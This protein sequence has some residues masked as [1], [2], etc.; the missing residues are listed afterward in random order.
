MIELYYTLFPQSNCLQYFI[1]PWY[2]GYMTSLAKHLK[3]I[4]PLGTKA[5]WQN[6]SKKQRSE[7]MRKVRQ[8]RLNKKGTNEYQTKLAEPVEKGMP[9]VRKGPAGL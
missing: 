3:K 5:R 4:S 8:S 2:N 7:I 9:N 6:V 1:V